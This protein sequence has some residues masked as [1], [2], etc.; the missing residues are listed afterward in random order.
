MAP[1]IGAQ[2]ASRLTSRTDFLFRLG[3]RGDDR[4]DQ[5]ACGLGRLVGVVERQHAVLDQD[6]ADAEADEELGGLL[7]VDRADVALL[8][9]FAQA[10]GEEGAGE[11]EVGAA[12][13]R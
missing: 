2:L 10:G 1:G 9:G 7:D 3:R 13:G 6:E 8:L 11:G 5:A 4:R 12:V